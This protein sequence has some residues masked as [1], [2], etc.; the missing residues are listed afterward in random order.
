MFIN[1]NSSLLIRVLDAVSR[2]YR[3]AFWCRVFRALCRVLESTSIWFDHSNFTSSISYQNCKIETECGLKQKRRL[4]IFLRGGDHRY[5]L[6][7][8]DSKPLFFFCDCFCDCCFFDARLNLT[9]AWCVL[10]N[11]CRF[12]WKFCL[13]PL[14]LMN[15]D[16][17]WWLNLWFVSER[18]CFMN[19]MKT[20]LWISFVNE[21]R[22]SFIGLWIQLRMLKKLMLNSHE[23]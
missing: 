11:E 8:F 23:M 13:N 4:T 17:V 18:N 9:L 3:I 7:F 1:S 20:G 15:D 16:S 5:R 10:V 14:L 19:I 12:F 22:I 21:C 2:S 6:L